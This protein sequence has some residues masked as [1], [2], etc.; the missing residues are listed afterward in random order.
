M[1]LPRR[2]ASPTEGTAACPPFAPVCQ[3]S[4][5]EIR[6]SAHAVQDVPIYCRT[7]CNVPAQALVLQALVGVERGGGRAGICVHYVLIWRVWR[8]ILAVA[9]AARMFN[10]GYLVTHLAHRV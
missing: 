2:A 1:N 5:S 3:A 10:R 8:F 6:S 4:L 9:H 7:C